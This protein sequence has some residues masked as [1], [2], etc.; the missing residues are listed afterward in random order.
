[1]RAWELQDFG[2][3]HLMLVE[4]PVPEPAPGQV[5]VRVGAAA[6]NSRDLQIVHDQYYP[7]QRLPIVLGSDGAGEVVA[8]G[9]GVERF[10]LGDRVAGAFAQGWVSGERTPERWLTH[11]GGHLDGVLQEYVLFDAEGAIAVPDYL[12]DAEAAAATSAAATAW[13]A[14]VELGGVRPG[15]TVLVQGTGGVAIFALQFAV[16][17]GARAIVTSSSDAKLARAQ[18]LGAWAGVNYKTHPDW[19]HEVLRLTGGAGVDHVVETA[20]DLA[21]SIACL[22]VGGLISALGYVSQLDLDGGSPSDWTYTAPVIPALVQNMRLQALSCAPRESF[23]RMYSAMAATELHP[24][25]DRIF[26]LEATDEAFRYLL[27]G[28]HFGKVCIDVAGGL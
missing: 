18:E 5:L 7:D 16:L 14:L 11:L 22:R 17:A 21:R 20:G 2:L 6:L 10:A 26:P 13:R 15:D 9:E 3:E 25:I 28:A 4:R 27:S 12:T 19:Q 8:L 24:A 1:M 23:E